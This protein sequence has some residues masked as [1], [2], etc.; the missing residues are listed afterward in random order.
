MLDHTLMLSQFQYRLSACNELCLGLYT[1]AYLDPQDPIDEDD[2]DYEPHPAQFTRSPPL[3]SAELLEKCPTVKS[4]TSTDAGDGKPRKRMLIGHIISTQSHNDT[5]KDA[6]ME[7]PASWSPDS[8]SS[9]T[10]TSKL[11]EGQSQETKGHQQFGPTICLHSLAILPQYKGLGLGTALLAA[12]IERMKSAGGTDRIA[13][14]AHDE[15]VPYYEKFGFYNVGK[16]QAT[17]G[18]A[19]W[20]DMVFT[21]PQP[22]E[23]PIQ[24]FVG[25]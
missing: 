21:F 2:D 20:N 14:L 25:R 7:I 19:A 16:S 18:G 4:A 9:S 11:A 24:S 3:P 23:P 17:F 10:T 6:D 5:I 12:Y 8:K 15:L 1:T 22:E 13:L